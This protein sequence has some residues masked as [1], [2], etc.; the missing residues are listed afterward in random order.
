[1]SS[2]RNKMNKLEF[3]NYFTPYKVISLKDIRKSIPNFSYRQ[4]NR[5]ERDGFLSKIKQGFYTFSDQELNEYFL[6]LTAN[7]IYAPSYISLERALKFYGLIPEEIFQVSSVSTKKT[8]KFNNFI[9]NFNYHH[10]KPS[11]FWGYR[12]MDFD[13]QKILI[14][15][16][17]KA[18]LDYL[19]LHPELKT[20][21]DFAEMR[22]NKHFFIENINLKKLYIYLELFNNKAL[23]KRVKVFLSTIQND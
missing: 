14:A 16:A 9:G 23:T 19:Y 15:E 17:E 5:W 2:C 1:M 4:I 20:K 3:K 11:L 22:I 21:N 12:F 13:E 18:I 8:N 10:I 7:R 6:F